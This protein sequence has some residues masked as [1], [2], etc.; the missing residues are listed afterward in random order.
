MTINNI[1]NKIT[2]LLVIYGFK[3]VTLPL[4]CKKKDLDLFQCKAG[5]TDL[6][7]NILRPQMSPAWTSIIRKGISLPEDCFAVGPCFPGESNKEDKLPVYHVVSILSQ[8]PK[9]KLLK[10][11]LKILEKFLT[12]SPR[13][14]D[15]PIDKHRY[16]EIDSII[17]LKKRTNSEIIVAELG[18][19]RKDIMQRGKL[20]HA[21]NVGIGIEQLRIAIHDN[22]IYNKRT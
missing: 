11:T 3:Q 4:I 16:L 2:D 1:E 22:S 19:Y 9:T 21:H 8:K 6:K 15:N 10:I 5:F 18:T 14:Y 12:K 13:V 7:N 17:H 20:T